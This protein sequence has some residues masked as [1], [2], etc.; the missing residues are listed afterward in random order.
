[1]TGRVF[2]HRL[3][4]PV[5]ILILL[6]LSN[7][8][9]TPTFF[10]IEVK[11]GH[12]YG[13]VIDILRLGAPLILVG[14]GMTLVIGTGG[15]DLS[16]GSVVAIAGAVA[17]GHIAG[18]PDQNSVSGVLVAIVMSI[19]LCLALGAWN[20]FLVAVLGIQPIIGT[21]VLMVAGR[22]IAQLIT[23]GQITTINSDPYYLIGGGYWL[24]LPFSILVALAVFALSALL[25]RRSA[26][27]LLL[28]AVGGNAEAS[29]L[30][31]I[32]SRRLVWLVYI[33]C[34]LTAGI[35][36][37]MISSNVNSADGTAAGLWIELD[38]IL[39]VVIGGTALTGGRFSLVGTVVGALLIQTLTTTILTIGVPPTTVMLVKALVVTAVCLLQSPNFRAKMPRRREK[40][41]PGLDAQ[42]LQEQRKVPA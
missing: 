26:L 33:F 24:G 27:G 22:G 41:T 16:V 37:L 36:G 39:A 34:A 28:E 6:L 2:R 25:V 10:S 17:C 12:L 40:P 8:F 42:Q 13:S 11:Q 31:G 7:L 32:R 30:T 9:F 1:M 21:L 20:G 35:A 19:G 29:R 38:A 23:D 4:W 5:A 14:L 18:L 3:F 15:I